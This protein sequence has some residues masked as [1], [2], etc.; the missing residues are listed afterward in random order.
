MLTY[1][2]DQK[3]QSCKFHPPPKF[4]KC[5]TKKKTWIPHCVSGHSAVNSRIPRDP[6]ATAYEVKV[7]EIPPI[8]KNLDS[9]LCYRTLGCKLMDLQRSAGH[10]LRTT[11]VKKIRYCFIGYYLTIYQWKC[12]DN[13]ET[14]YLQIR[15]GDIES[16]A[17]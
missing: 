14:P 9:T 12:L 10:S 5:F 11:G 8:E 17:W 15:D 2:L 13:F 1:D 3:F 6:W 4:K 16:H 7:S